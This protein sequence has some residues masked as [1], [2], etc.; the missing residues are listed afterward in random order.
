MAVY[1]NTKLRRGI[2]S[3]KSRSKLTENIETT[4]DNKKKAE[5][6]TMEDGELSSDS[7][8][9][10]K[11]PSINWANYIDGQKC[12]KHRNGTCPENSNNRAVQLGP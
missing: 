6:N 8:S 12:A 3:H 7:E 2:N 4:S 1:R 5:R 10:L 9:V 11:V